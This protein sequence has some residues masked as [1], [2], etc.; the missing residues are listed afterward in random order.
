MIINPLEKRGRD[1][2]EEGRGG[3]D[4]ILKTLYTRCKKYLG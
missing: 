4:T 2:K 1:G 3:R